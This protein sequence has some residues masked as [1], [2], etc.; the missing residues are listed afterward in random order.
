MFIRF[1]LT[2]VTVLAVSPH[3]FGDDPTTFDNVRPIIADHC[4]ICHN[5]NGEAPFALLTF[6]DVQRR[7]K[8][9]V[10]VTQR[11]Y[12]PPWLPRESDFPFAHDRAMS[13]SEIDAI[14]NWFA[15]GMKRGT[16]S[17]EP[18]LSPTDT[19]NGW[20][21]R[22]GKPDLVLSLPK[23]FQL[24]ADGPE[25]FWN[26]VVPTEIAGK[27]FV[28]TV[29]INPGN[30]RAVHHIVGLID[31]TGTARRLAEKTG[32]TPLG[33]PGMEVANANVPNGQSMLW[34]PGKAPSTGEDGIAWELDSRT[35]IVLQMHMFPSGKPEQISPQLGIYF[36]D[37][38][39]TKEAISFML[40]ARTI[41]IPPGERNYVVEDEVKLPVDLQ[42]LS[43]YPHAHY[44]ATKFLCTAILPDGEKKIL[45]RI[46][47]WDFAWQDEYKF[48]DPVDMPVGTVIRMQIEYDNS[49]KN[50]RNPNAPP[51]RVVLGNNSTDEM[52]KILFQAIAK[53]TTDV[54][55]MNESRWRQK[56][57]TTPLHPTANQNL[58]N[59]LESRGEF[60]EALGHYELVLQVAPEDCT[61]HDNLACVLDRLGRLDEAEKHFRKAIDLNADYPLAY[62][63]WGA[64]LMR[65][66][67]VLEALKLLNRAVEIWPEFPEARINLGEAELLRGQTARAKYHFSLAA[68]QNPNYALA[69]FN[70]G[71]V[72]MNSRDF[73]NAAKSFRRAIECKPEFAE[74]YNNL[75]ITH[76]YRDE[77]EEAAKNFRRAL[78]LSPDYRNAQ[79]NL[80][81]V[82]ERLAANP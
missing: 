16:S 73:E 11:R 13:E 57:K 60:V 17:S 35:D 46:D 4:S 49:A 65:Q 44:L 45:L 71:T 41:D 66:G 63:H 70:L 77:L 58:G 14:Q 6:D 53:S 29:D 61:A 25:V 47:D 19:K 64:S 23:S 3:A 78:E 10:E 69:H 37:G 48:R 38:P 79:Q 8:Q 31:G 59:I 24:P 27:R 42:L 80:R 22:L 54:A 81:T 21:W 51:K 2:V 72:L 56:L 18:E 30:R 74:A 67:R 32:S 52:G 28:K 68:K 9:I 82:E 40:E 62:N 55:A 36:A 75:G 5:S 26:F 15:A 12:M 50:P 34:S 39:P 33:F 76:F 43:L 1:C 20:H 7:G